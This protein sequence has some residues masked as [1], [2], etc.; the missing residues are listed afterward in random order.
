VAGFED[1]GPVGTWQLYGDTRRK[2]RLEH[3]RA[4]AE[5]GRWSEVELEAEELL[6]EVADDPEALFLL[7]E[8]SLAL[9]RFDVA[10]HAYAR[11]MAVDPA[12]GA[13]STPA[14]LSGLALAYFHTCSVHEAAQLARDVIRMDPE[15][16][17]AH[18][19][20]S[21]A[22]DFLPGRTA[23]ALAAR[24]AAAQLEPDRYPLPAPRRSTHWEE[25][26][27][28]ALEQ[29]DVRVRG[30]YAQVP[31]R[32]EELP[33]LEEL[34][35]HTPPTSPG[36]IALTDGDPPGPGDDEAT[37]LPVGVRVFARNLERVGP[38]E[39]MVR[40]LAHELDEEARLWLTP[41]DE[42]E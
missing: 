13:V 15:R 36:V 33:D 4:A 21:M 28:Q 26:I 24:M 19:V 14:L 39:V 35:A 31:F 40:A 32:V 42:E 6:D 18:H 27:G 29:V 8:A 16:A 41:D 12:G 17:E 2:L 9:G 22:L 3:L 23:E 10:R 38:G 11:V 30:F 34:R 25:L 37:V 7:G 5:A 1:D 20:L